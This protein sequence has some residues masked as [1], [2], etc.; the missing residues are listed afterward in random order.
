M[1]YIKLATFKP[2]EVIPYV[3]L[4][5][6]VRGVEKT[7]SPLVK[8]KE[9]PF[10]KRE[11]AGY[12]VKLTSDRYRLFAEKGLKCVNC[13]VVGSVFVMERSVSQRI[14]KRWINM[15]S[16]GQEKEFFEW[17]LKR[18]EERAKTNGKLPN[19]NPDCIWHF[20]LYAAIPDGKMRMMTKDHIIPRSKGG[21]NCMEN[22][23]PMCTRCNGQKGDKISKE[24]SNGLK[25]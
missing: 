9:L 16:N 22:Y 8:E 1:P 7:I 12:M 15:R 3:R 24:I 5:T 13:G 18:A 17:E 14:Y 20:N 10:A 21:Q 11:Y 19:N 6:L 25:K 4:A 2:E 23:Q